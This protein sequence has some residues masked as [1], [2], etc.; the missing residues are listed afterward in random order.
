[1]ELAYNIHD[2]LKQDIIDNM[3]EYIYNKSVEYILQISISDDAF[4][5][6]MKRSLESKDYM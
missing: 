2:C 6:D 1:M 3:E 5:T 4:G